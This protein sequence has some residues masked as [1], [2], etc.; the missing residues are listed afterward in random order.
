MPYFVKGFLYIKEYWG[1]HFLSFDAFFDFVD[2]PV[3]LLYCRVVERYNMIEEKDWQCCTAANV[4]KVDWK[5]DYVAKQ[6]FDKT[7]AANVF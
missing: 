4:K 5:H 7:R 6:A 2:N 1:A 3:A